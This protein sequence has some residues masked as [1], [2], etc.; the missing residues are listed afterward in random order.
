MKG[1]FLLAVLFSFSVVSSSQAKQSAKNDV[2]FERSKNLDIFNSLYKELDMFYVDSIKPDKQIKYGIDAMLEKLDPYTTYIPE[3]ELENFKFMTT[4]EYAGVGAVIG[5]RDGHIYIMDL[6]EGMPAHK[7]GLKVGDELIEVGGVSIPGKTT[8]EASE[9]LKGQAK[10][11]VKVVVARKGQAKKQTLS[12]VRDKISISPVAYYGLYDGNIGY[13][14]FTGFTENC[15]ELFK[16][17]FQALKKQG[18]TSLIVDLRDNPGGILSEVVKMTNFFVEKKSMIVYTKG[19]MKQWDE[20]YKATREPI[21]RNIPIVVLVNEYSA[22]AAEIFSGALQDLDRAVIVGSRTYGKGLVQTTR[23]LP[24]GGNLKVTISKYYI[25]SGRCI[26]AIDYANRNSDGY[27][28]RIPDSLTSV[29]H[30]ANGREVR[31]GGGITPDVA[32]ETPKSA[33]ISYYLYSK[34][35]IFEYANEYVLS[36]PNIPSPSNFEFKDYDDFKKYVKKSGFTY[37]LKTEE[38]LKTLTSVAKDEGY[39]DLYKDDIS[40]LEKKMAHD[41]DKDLDLFQDEIKKLISA[42]I[43]KRFYFQKGEIQVCLKNDK[44]FERAREI[45]KNKDEYKRLLS[46]EKSKEESK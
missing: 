40:S 22:S 15:A 21:D 35:V 7:A 32:V 31:D 42:E 30:T 39:Y 2:N 44:A 17:A 8:N 23:E 18:A 26:Q 3:S 10:S 28:Q 37:S 11:T 36:H 25:P 16:N 19:K 41:L 46:P 34:N 27:V 43:V 13:I 45:L 14:N 38:V 6:Y 33:T 24:Y 29:F 5:E 20:T 4:G 1:K 9:L 12:V